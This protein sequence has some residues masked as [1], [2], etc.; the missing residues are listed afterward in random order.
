MKWMRGRTRLGQTNFRPTLLGDVHTSL[1]GI[2]GYQ[3]K[4]GLYME[5]QGEELALYS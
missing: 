1:E 3:F 2:N 5:E 4:K